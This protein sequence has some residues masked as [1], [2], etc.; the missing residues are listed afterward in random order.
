[1]WTPRVIAPAGLLAASVLGIGSIA[2]LAQRS[3]VHT[4]LGDATVSRTTPA[5][6]EPMIA[7]GGNAELTLAAS[8][9]NAG[10]R[11]RGNASLFPRD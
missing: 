9:L 7:S 3:A 8:G 10:H 11:V 1:M 6:S 5:P 2:V 4:G